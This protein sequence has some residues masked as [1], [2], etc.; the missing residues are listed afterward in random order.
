MYAVDIKP[1]QIRNAETV[2]YKDQ[3]VVANML[4]NLGLHLELPLVL[5]CIVVALYVAQK[6]PPS[7]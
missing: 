2:G 3:I 6:L 7:A 1:G 5:Y 4:Q